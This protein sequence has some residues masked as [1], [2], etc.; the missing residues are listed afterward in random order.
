M[1]SCQRCRKPLENPKSIERGYGP[2][3]Y[4]KVKKD[5]KEEVL[6]KGEQEDNDY[7]TLTD[8]L[9][10]LDNPKCMN[11]KADLMRYGDIDH[12]LHEGG[13]PLKNYKDPQ[14][15]FLICSKCHYDNALKKLLHFYGKKQKSLELYTLPKDEKIESK[16]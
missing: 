9:M 12:Y 10:K 6:D 11:C 7:P 5:W 15:I 13:H 2:I 4:S 3:C 14:W 1:P 8:Y 16:T